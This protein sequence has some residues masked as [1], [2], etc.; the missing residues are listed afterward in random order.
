MGVIS[1]AARELIAAGLDGD[2][3]CAA[4]ERIES[5]HKA[6]DEQAE[7]RRAKDRE[8]KRLRNSAESAESAETHPP[9]KKVSPKPPSK[10]T[11]AFD[12]V[13]EGAREIGITPEQEQRL[14]QAALPAINEAH[15][16]FLTMAV[17]LSWLG[18]GASFDA[19]VIPAVRAASI[20]GPPGRVMSWSW[21]TRAVADHHAA[22]T[23]TLPQGDPRATSSSRRIKRTFFDTCRD[24]VRE[25]VGEGLA[26]RDD[27]NPRLSLS[28]IPGS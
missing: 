19:D 13:V 8:R 15:P 18:S 21:F 6:V 12:V 25:G 14:R 4:L 5:F 17:P 9:P 16:N 10:N 28:P 20:R 11:P 24:F 3:L 26:G 1:A 27:E 2:R 22:R 7:R 23:S